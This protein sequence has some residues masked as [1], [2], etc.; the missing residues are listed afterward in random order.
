MFKNTKFARL[1][2]FGWE[3]TLQVLSS[4]LALWCWRVVLEEANCDA[5][6]A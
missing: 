1:S 5:V 6:L 3:G 2:V 4:L